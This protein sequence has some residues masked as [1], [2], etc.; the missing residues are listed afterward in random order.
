MLYDTS[1]KMVY[2]YQEPFFTPLMG[3]LVSEHVC[4][5][6]PIPHTQIHAPCTHPNQQ[7]TH[8][9][10]YEHV[11]V[12]TPISHILTPHVQAQTNKLHSMKIMSLVRSTGASKAP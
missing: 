12:L 9:V 3:I 6:T 7:T 5:L 8:I 4:V 2:E 1:R 10:V 11:C